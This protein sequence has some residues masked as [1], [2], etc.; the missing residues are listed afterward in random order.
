[1][2][3]TS[4]LSISTLFLVAAALPMAD[5]HD[6]DSSHIEDGKAISVDPIVRGTPQ[7]MA[8]NHQIGTDG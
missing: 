4:S 2:A 1:M 6:H 3:P 5:G 7:T 8:R